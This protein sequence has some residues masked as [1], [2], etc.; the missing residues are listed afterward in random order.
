MF[1]VK[2]DLKIKININR[3]SE[4]GSKKTFSTKKVIFY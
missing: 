4:S 2:N 1:D 3:K